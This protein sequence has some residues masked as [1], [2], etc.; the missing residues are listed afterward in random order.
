[1]KTKEEKIIKDN[2]KRRRKRITRRQMGKQTKEK[3]NHGWPICP[4]LIFLK[5]LPFATTKYK[6][7]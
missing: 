5:P 7:T 3:E 2:M 1:L 6:G 4:C